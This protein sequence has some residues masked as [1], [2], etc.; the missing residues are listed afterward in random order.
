MQS[1]V[2]ITKARLYVHEV[3]DAQLGDAVIARALD[4]ALIMFTVS[5]LESIA[6][7]FLAPVLPLNVIH[8]SGVQN[9]SRT[10]RARHSSW[11]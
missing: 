10:L 7:P 8:L 5:T 6:G 9:W 2:Q 11:C 3:V 4:D 1:S